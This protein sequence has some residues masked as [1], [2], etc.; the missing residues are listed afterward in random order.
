M[1]FIGKLLAYPLLAVKIITALLRIFS[2]YGSM[3]APIGKWPFASL[4]GLAFPFLFIINLLFLLFWL[5][6]WK[7]GAL[8]PLATILVCI[9]SILSYFPLHF[10]KGKNV[11]APYLTV[12]SYNTEGLGMD[13]NKDWALTNPVLNYILD[14]N[15]DM[16]FL[17]EAPLDVMNRAAKDK[18]ILSKYPHISIAEKSSQFACL[19][20]FPVIKQEIIKFENSGNGCQYLKILVN[21]DTLAV[22]NCHFQ[23]NQLK[24]A[25]ISEYQKFIENPADSTHLEASKKVVKKLLKS[26][27]LRATQARMISDRARS[28]TAKYL[29]VCGD[30]NDT[31]LSYSHHV[32]HRFMTDAYARSGAGT[33]YT[34]HEQKL[35]YRIDHIFCNKNIT[36]LHTR[37]DRVQKDSDHY[38]VISKIRLE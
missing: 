9:P 24:Q 13:D 38:P 11:K 37:I 4:S 2:C 36:P 18:G 5:L 1:K 17:Q 30:F 27:S 7:K 29:I 16:V 34:Y 3:A 33:G 10:F 32:F 14:L 31:P 8:V 12:I 15:A 6:I 28:E 35:Y 22:Y 19:S 20:K 26:T 21:N 25:E 23:S